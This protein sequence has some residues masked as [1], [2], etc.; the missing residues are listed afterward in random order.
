[1]IR[2]AANLV[3]KVFFRKIYFSGS[4]YT[5]KSAIWVANHSSGIVDPTL[6]VGLAPV[7]IRP[8]SKSSLWKNPVL[9]FF[10]KKTGAIPVTR[11]QDLDPKIWQENNNTEDEMMQDPMIKINESTFQTVSGALRNGDCILI[12]P[13]GTSHDDPYIHPFKS[14]FARMA[15]ATL[16]SA[17]DPNFFV[18]IQP[19]VVDYSEKDEFRSDISMHYCEPVAVSSVQISSKILT[20]KV[21]K[22]MEG[23]FASFINWDEKRNWRFLFEIINKRSTMSAKEFR[24]FVEK[25]RPEFDKDAILTTRIQTTRRL[26]QAMNIRPSE[27]DWGSTHTNHRFYLWMLFKHG[28]FYVFITFP[29]LILGSVVWVFPSKFCETLANKTENRDVKATMKIAHAIWFFPL[30]AFIASSLFTFFTDLYFPGNSHIAVW[31][32]FLVLTPTF[33]ILS[34]ILSESINFFPSFLRLT[35]LRIFFPRFWQETI[36]EWKEFT[37]QITEKAKKAEET[38]L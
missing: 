28:W 27:L 12:F 24:D 23:G 33:L 35:L 26:L 34:I 1:M 7:K 2:F 5:G 17:N 20:E 25:F 32:A 29:I 21:R 38:M 4:P 15:L 14:G 37:S 13:E 22:S 30:W 36:C 8:L 18:V 6:F 9:Q 11:R 3:C 10:L 19:V 16:N 31:F